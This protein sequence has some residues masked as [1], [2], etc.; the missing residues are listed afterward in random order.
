M[1]RKTIR[2]VNGKKGVHTGAV[3]IKV[4][5]NDVREK[6]SHCFWLQYGSG[7]VTASHV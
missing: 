4:G 5:P 7:N 2:K 6:T 1:V 3:L